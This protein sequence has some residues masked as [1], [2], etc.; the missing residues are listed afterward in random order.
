MAIIMFPLQ[1]APLLDSYYSCRTTSPP[2]HHRESGFD[3]IDICSTLIHLECW[4]MD[5]FFPSAP[6]CYGIEAATLSTHILKTDL[7]KFKWRNDKVLF[8]KVSVC[9]WCC[10][11][12]RGMR[13]HQLLSMNG[14]LLDLSL[15]IISSSV[16]I[17]TLIFH[18]CFF[19]HG[20]EERFQA[21]DFLFGKKNSDISGI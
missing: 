9:S 19:W 18:G 20:S 21:F 1:L 10:I 16:K 8:D 6:S 15:S 2:P 7:E 4:Y 11:A 5:L 17:N 12:P 3:G 13:G 14:N